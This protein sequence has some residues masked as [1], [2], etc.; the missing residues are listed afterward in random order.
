MINMHYVCSYRRFLRT[1]TIPGIYTQSISIFH[2][3]IWTE[4]TFST[5]TTITGCRRITGLRA[6]GTTLLE[7]LSWWTRH[8]CKKIGAFSYVRT[9]ITIINFG[10]CKHSSTYIRI[11]ALYVYLLCTYDRYIFSSLVNG[12][13]Q[14]NNHQHKLPNCRISHLLDHR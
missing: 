8:G 5:F 2:L 1:C 13:Q 12:L 7:S 9:Y 4:A 10:E 6:Q 3:A 14:K 11:W